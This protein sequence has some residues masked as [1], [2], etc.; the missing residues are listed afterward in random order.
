[1][2]ISGQNCVSVTCASIL[3]FGSAIAFVSKRDGNPDIYLL[4]QGDQPTLNLTADS[5]LNGNPVWSPDGTLIAFLREYA[6]ITDI[7]VMN[8]DGSA[9][10]KVLSGYGLPVPSVPVWSPDGAKLAFT[11]GDEI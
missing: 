2:S 5:A 10:V 9:R 3:P 8:A 11:G 6:A 4:R 7:Y 1:M